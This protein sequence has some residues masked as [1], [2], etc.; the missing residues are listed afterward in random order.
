MDEP[1]GKPGNSGDSRATI[2]VVKGASPRGV[3]SLKGRLLDA[4]EF[5]TTGKPVPVVGAKISLLGTTFSTKTNRTGAFTLKKVP[6]GT[7]VLDI[8]GS[9]ARKA[10]P[11]LAEATKWLVPS[12][13]RVPAT[14]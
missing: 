9:A 3:T 11:E 6:S 8:D 13:T 2:L 14:T 1:H 12:S 7:Q 5:A 10:G 4:N